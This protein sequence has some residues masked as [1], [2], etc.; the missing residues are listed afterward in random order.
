MKPEKQKY[1]E[2]LNIFTLIELLVVIAIIAILVSML[3]PALNKARAMAHSANCLNNLKQIGLGVA[4]Y[5]QDHKG[6]Y[7]P[8]Y[9]HPDWTYLLAENKYTGK[10]VFVCHGRKSQY[11][12]INQY[13]DT[14]SWTEGSYFWRYPDYGYNFRNIGSHYDYDASDPRRSN[15]S[16][17]DSEIKY[18]TKTVLIVDSVD[19]G[20]TAGQDY[21]S[22][23]R[24]YVE[25]NYSATAPQASPSHEKSCNTLWIDGHVSAVGTVANAG[26]EGKIQR[27]Y[28]SGSLGSRYSEGGGVNYWDRR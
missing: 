5:T 7:M 13:F 4:S 27:L 15:A 22:R 16:A 24:F 21:R 1:Q 9:G 28:T 25:S 14:T 23:G 19:G 17:R 20:T 12:G 11:S 10:K 3:L 2:K 18:P 8:Y 6:Y 26:I